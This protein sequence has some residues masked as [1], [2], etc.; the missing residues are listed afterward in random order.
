M[1]DRDRIKA[2]NDLWFAFSEMFKFSSRFVASVCLGI[3][4]NRVEKRILA[5]IMG[6]DPWNFAINPR[7]LYLR[8]NI[9]ARV[10]KS[11]RMRGRRNIPVCC[12]N[13][14]SR[15][16]ALQTCVSRITLT[17]ES[18]AIFQ[19]IKPKFLP[20]HEWSKP[21]NRARTNKQMETNRWNRKLVESSPVR[22]WN[23]T[24]V[25]HALREKF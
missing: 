15:Q 13:N 2:W 18:I 10:M 21:C 25:E 24:S 12:S 17:I 4:I 5:Y 6:I 3:C 19:S 1:E 22:K 14:K 7:R 16:I 8:W 11:L 20:F 9:H 23:S